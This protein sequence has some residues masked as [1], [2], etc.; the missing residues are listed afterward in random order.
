MNGKDLMDIYKK[1]EET[2]KAFKERIEYLVNR[3]Q[4]LEY[5]VAKYEKAKEETNKED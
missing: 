3:I 5:K 1:F 2:E 4:K